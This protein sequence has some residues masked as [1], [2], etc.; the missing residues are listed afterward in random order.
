M[1][2][3]TYVQ[4]TMLSSTKLDALAWWVKWSVKWRLHIQFAKQFGVLFGPNIGPLWSKKFWKIFGPNI[5]LH[6]GTIFGPNKNPN[7]LT[8]W[9][10]PLKCNKTGPK[11]MSGRS[12]E[13]R[14]HINMQA[15]R[16]AGISRWPW[17]QA[18]KRNGSK[19]TK[20]T[21]SGTHARTFV[22]LSVGST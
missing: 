14:D 11:I 7:R 13:H 10:T 8:N 12:R 20:N 21:K 15:D 5:K 4:L 6:K 16:Q 9:M 2:V 19:Y 17:K 1:Y 22:S 18:A 3:C